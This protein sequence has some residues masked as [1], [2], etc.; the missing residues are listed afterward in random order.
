MPSRPDGEHPS[1]DRHPLALADARRCGSLRSPP[2]Q[3]SAKATSTQ[4]SPSR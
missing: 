3:A 4:I 2:R 1:R